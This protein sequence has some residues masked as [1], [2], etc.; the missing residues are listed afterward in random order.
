MNALL[1][2]MQI[3]PDLA[4]VMAIEGH[5]HTVLWQGQTLVCSIKGVLKKTGIFIRV[6]DAVTLDEISPPQATARIVAVAPRQT[7][8]ERPRIANV[9]QVLVTV[10]CEQPLFSFETVDRLLAHAKLSGLQAVI[11]LTKTDLLSAKALETLLQEMLSVYQSTLGIQV[12]PLSVFSKGVS[13][14]EDKLALSSLL[15]GHVSV[16]AGPSGVGKSSLLNA[17]LPHASLKTG[18]ISQ[19]LQRGTHTTRH[20]ALL[21]LDDALDNVLQGG[22]IADTPGF[23]QLTFQDYSPIAVRNAFLELSPSES[24]GG[25][26]CPFDDCLHE[27]HDTTCTLKPGIHIKPSRYASYLG[28]LLEAKAGQ[29]QREARSQK[30]SFGLRVRDGKHGQTGLSLRLE[31][32]HRQ[33]GRNTER[34]KASRDMACEQLQVMADDAL[35][36][37][38]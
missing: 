23:S 2:A 19:K 8:L 24:G 20:V 9:T 35:F 29:V 17:L 37:E 14:A 28:M 3:T 10:A 26:S 18:E 31:G 7:S 16:L 30:S 32:E 25:L 36:E 33:A 13:T 6:G 34:Q 38:D 5:R 4:L 22:L 1:T 15:S 21:P 12:L 27:P 11:L